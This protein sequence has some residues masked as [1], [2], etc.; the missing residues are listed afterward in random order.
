MGCADLSGI[1]RGGDA[2]FE[3]GIMPAESRM[4]EVDD[5]KKLA[6]RK[7]L[8]TEETSIA[9]GCFPSLTSAHSGS[10]DTERAVG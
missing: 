4:D 7:H 2:A 9:N 8:E 3:R 10:R 1:N 6:E 5:G